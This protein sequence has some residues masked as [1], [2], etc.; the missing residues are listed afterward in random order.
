M[1]DF[2][3]LRA[4]RQNIRNLDILAKRRFTVQALSI[5]EEIRLTDGDTR[6]SWM[7]KNMATYVCG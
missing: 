3:N 4:L 7:V 2:P 5:I 1:D 6:I